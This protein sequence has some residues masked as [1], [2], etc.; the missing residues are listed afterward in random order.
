MVSDEKL[1]K[2]AMAYYKG[3][4]T[5]MEIAKDLGVSHVQVG[6]YLKLAQDRGIVEIRVNAPFVPDGES[7]RISLYIKEMFGLENLILAPSAANESLTLKFLTDSVSEYLLKTFRN[8]SLNI[9][10]GYGKTMD[11]VSQYKVRTVDKRSQWTVYPVTNYPFDSLSAQYDYF[12]YESLVQNFMQNW[13][14]KQDRPFMGIIKDKRECDVS[15]LWK[16]LDVIVGGI[17]VPFSRSPEAREAMFGYETAEKYALSDIQGDYINYFFDDAGHIIEP[18]AQSPYRIDVQTLKQVPV[19]IAVASSFQKVYS[20][21]G[22]LKCGL[23]NTLVT[24]LVTARTI[25]EA[26][27]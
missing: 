17:G 11:G 15:D 9:G 26:I 25:V 16:R 22:L 10:F 4:R 21:I 13:G 2:I 5:Q 24:D 8:E 12:S 3:G 19:K 1:F 27:R 14:T 18:L 20:I 23:V 6:K 7:N